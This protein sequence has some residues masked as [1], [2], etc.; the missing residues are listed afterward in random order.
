MWRFRSCVSG[1]RGVSREGSRVVEYPDDGTV[2]PRRARTRAH[3]RRRLGVFLLALL[4]VGMGAALGAWVV[5]RLSGARTN[6]NGGLPNGGLPAVSSTLVA[7]VSPSIVEIHVRT[8]TMTVVGSGIVL[9]TRGD[10]VTNAHVVAGAVRIV[11]VLSNGT[12]L[13]AHVV[14]ADATDDV[15][16][17]GV[18]ARGLRP[19]AFGDSSRLW[20]GQA[21]VAFGSPFGLSGSVSTGIVSALHRVVAVPTAVPE[22][23]V[24]AVQTNAAINPGNSGGALVDAAG[25]VIAMNTA[26][27]SNGA[28]DTG[29]GFALPMQRVLPIARALVAHRA[30]VVPYLGVKG[31]T[32]LVPGITSPAGPLNPPGALVEGVAAGSPAARAGVRSGDVIVALNGQ[33]VDGWAQFVVA[34]RALHPGTRV[35]LRVLRGTTTRMLDATLQGHPALQGR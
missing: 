8:A 34:L 1:D 10:I 17:V 20:V 6:T 31:A 21:V 9:N 19:A 11:V 29:V 35:R 4:A 3:A 23:L 5:L 13:S 14:G 18:T 33:R 27:V 16:V 22:V 32:G 24:D 15:A 2:Q 26:L 7:H 30:I 25:R 28:F 12:R